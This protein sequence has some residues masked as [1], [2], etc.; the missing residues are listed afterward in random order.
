MAQASV[1]APT[2]LLTPVASIAPPV[3]KDPAV[4]RRLASGESSS[5][6]QAVPDCSRPLF[7]TPTTPVSITSSPRRE[8][9]RHLVFADSGPAG[10]RPP[11]R[12]QTGHADRL[13]ARHTCFVHG[14]H[15]VPALTRPVP[16]RALLRLTKILYLRRGDGSAA[17]Q[18]FPACARRSS[19]LKTQTP[20][21]RIAAL[22]REPRDA[23][24][25]MPRTIP[26]TI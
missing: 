20:Q 22:L 23:K 25:P 2:T 7:D 5:A 17:S 1:E 19:L 12:P 18:P 11:C 14:A 10:Q 24:P 15:P 9:H 6:V 26:L 3:A 8:H 13:A 21:E 16:C 4:Q